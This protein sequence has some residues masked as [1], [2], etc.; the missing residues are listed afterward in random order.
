MDYLDIAKS[1]APIYDILRP[2]DL[3]DDY[4]SSEDVVHHII[5][6]AGLDKDASISLVEPTS[7]FRSINTLKTAAN[8]VENNLADSV[9]TVEKITAPIGSLNK[10]GYWELNATIPNNL[11]RRAQNRIVHYKEVGVV[12][13]TKIANFINTNKISS[14][15]ILTVEV[16][17]VEALDINEMSD[18]LLANKI[19][20]GLKN[21]KW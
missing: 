19:Y 6:S 12:W 10:N 21:E 18:L 3:S 7:P 17:C 4:S 2:K 8:Y 15:R 13:V 5:S 1:C 20:S 11:M 16:S 14:G 9:I